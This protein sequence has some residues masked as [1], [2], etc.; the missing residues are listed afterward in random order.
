MQR[1]VF[2][3]SAF[4]SQEPMRIALVVNAV[5]PSIGGVLI[6]G[7]K[8]TGKSTAVRALAQLLPKI[9]AVDGCPFR[10]DPDAPSPLHGECADRFARGEA[11]P[12]K[13]IP[14]P[15]CELPLNA[16]EDRLVGTLHVEHALQ[17][18]QR[19]FEPGLLAASHRG[20]LYVDEVNLL[21]DHLVDLLLDTAASGVNTVE[22]DGVSVRHAARLLLVG[23]M[24]PEEGELR[25]QLLD[26]FG[27]CV[28]V[29]GLESRDEREAIVRRRLDYERNPAAFAAK[30]TEADEALAKTIERA[31]AQLPHVRLPDEMVRLAVRLASEAK[32]RGHRAEI[33]TIKTA[34]A[35]AA[36]VG[37][38]EVEPDEVADAA[39]YALPH[40]VRD[41]A[42][43]SPE[44]SYQ[45]VDALV[46]AAVSTA[47][48][49]DAAAALDDDDAVAL[50][51]AMQV[52]G[53]AAAGSILLAVEKKSSPTGS[54]TPTS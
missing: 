2:P 32:T 53:G 40:R 15:L 17:T 28:A 52:P 50:A 37:K 20:L 19:R 5:D 10:C 51:E 41:H 13:T 3:F 48:G 35:L 27:L 31:R 46:A 12:R 6:R 45:R 33:V 34:C 49:V 30:W 1:A 14:M 42:L 21:E 29:H 36:L 4:V 9:V 16:T 22:R 47:A 24:N 7:H 25:P 39:R 8:G 44:A 43:S 54:S 18:G 26:R 38:T 23:T 11:L